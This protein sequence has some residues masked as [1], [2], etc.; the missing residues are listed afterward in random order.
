MA[1]TILAVDSTAAHMVQK[2]PNIKKGQ[3]LH[4]RVHVKHAL[5]IHKNASE[6]AR[7]LKIM[8]RNKEQLL[9]GAYEYTFLQAEG[10]SR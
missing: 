6:S 5:E 10:T 4:L 9:Y 2:I 8:S 1:H 7:G 3:M